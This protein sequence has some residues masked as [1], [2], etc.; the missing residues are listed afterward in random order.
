MNV[1]NPETQPQ[2]ATLYGVLVSLK[3]CY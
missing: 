2:F 1:K 3:P